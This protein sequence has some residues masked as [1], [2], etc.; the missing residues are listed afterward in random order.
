MLSG[1]ASV[2]PGVDTPIEGYNYGIFQ[3]VGSLRTFLLA[4]GYTSAK[5]NIMTKNDMVYAAKLAG[6]LTEEEPVEEP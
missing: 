1:H 6:A 4:N 3:N 5:L 2:L